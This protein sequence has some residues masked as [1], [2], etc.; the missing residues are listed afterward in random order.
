MKL[1]V[2]LKIPTL[3]VVPQSLTIGHLCV[4]YEINFGSLKKLQSRKLQA[5]IFISLEDFAICSLQEELIPSY[6]L[7]EE[8]V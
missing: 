2:A 3:Q 8:L 4:R 7:G 6:L 1:S 5:F